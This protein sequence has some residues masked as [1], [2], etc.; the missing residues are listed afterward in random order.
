MKLKP[1]LGPYYIIQPVNIRSILQLSVQVMQSLLW[2]LK[3]LL[4]Q[5][6]WL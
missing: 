1:G 6:C 5:T 3:L 4:S 2:E